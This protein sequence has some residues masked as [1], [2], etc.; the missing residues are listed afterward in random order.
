MIYQVVYNYKVIKEFDDRQEAIMY[1]DSFFKC[2]DYDRS[3]AN[4]DIYLDDR[5][6]YSAYLNIS[7]KE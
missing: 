3:S 1:V 2:G 5:K 7:Y 4:V 6:I